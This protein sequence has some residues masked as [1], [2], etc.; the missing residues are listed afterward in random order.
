[1]RV[2]IIHGGRVLQSVHHNSQSFVMAPTEGDYVIRLINDSPSRK[3]AVPTV[4]GMN[5]VEV[6]KSGRGASH[7]GPGYVLEA[8]QTVDIPGWRRSG[9]EVASFS[10]APKG[11]S[12]AEG[13]GRGESNL[14][15]IGV[16]VFDEKP[17]PIQAIFAQQTIYR[18][19]RTDSP[20]EPVGTG[21][22]QWSSQPQT[23]GC[24]PRG[25]TKGIVRSAAVNS[26]STSTTA[27]VQS[28][29]TGYGAA[30][31]FH[32]GT[33]TFRRPAAPSEVIVLRYATQSQL[34]SWGVPLPGASA[35]TPAAFPGE[36][37]HAPCPA[38]PGWRG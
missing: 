22:P 8:W 6:D 38:P 18:S 7:S 2:E 21:Q 13:V 17:S 28:V 19:R 35:P 25:A 23:L 4:D 37:P 36:Q 26:L 11:E 30:Q 34:E 3:L 14:G 24:Q 1:M 5:V 15:V 12:Y 9:S 20:W 31:A 32:T 33:T 29:G 27:S 10:F 16:A